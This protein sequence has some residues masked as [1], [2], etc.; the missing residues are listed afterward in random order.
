[1]AEILDQ[2][3]LNSGGLQGAIEKMMKN[4]NNYRLNKDNKKI[5]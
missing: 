3:V 4:I 2:D 5:F 1:L